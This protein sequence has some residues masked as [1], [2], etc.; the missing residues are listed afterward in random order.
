MWTAKFWKATGERAVK[1][2][3]Q[4]ALIYFGA[5]ALDVWHTNWAAAAGI[6]LSAGL[7]SVLTSVVS[8]RVGDSSSP[9]LVTE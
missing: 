6:A 5:G 3:A 9:S 4:A 1:S 8:S 2:V 7:L